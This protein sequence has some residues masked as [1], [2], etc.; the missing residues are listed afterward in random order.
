MRANGSKAGN[1]PLFTLYRRQRVVVPST[2][3]TDA[4]GIQVDIN[5]KNT[6][7]YS[8]LPYYR[9]IS[10]S[11]SKDG[12]SL[13]FNSPRDL[14]IPQ[15]RFG[16]LPDPMLKLNPQF[17]LSPYR[18]DGGL[19]YPI[20]ALSSSPNY[21]ADDED[22]ATAQGPPANPV[23]SLEG[24][25]VM[26]TDVISFAVIPIFSGLPS[27]DW[28]PPRNTFFPKGARVY[29]TWSDRADDMYDYTVWDY[30]ANTNPLP[31]TQVPNKPIVTGLQ[32]SIR[33]WDEKTK[34]AR[35]ITVIQDL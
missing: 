6:T 1:L 32:I 15:R 26:L 5:Y 14:T 34:Q 19:R 8:D 30:P 17:T 25:D 24:A 10:T 3:M 31:Y 22:Q 28:D 23:S 35:Q 20:F 12:K 11:I 2:L 13:Y 4:N 21:L 16:I 18:S 33:V 9:D 7:P 29:D 27:P